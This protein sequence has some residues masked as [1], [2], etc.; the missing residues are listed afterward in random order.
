VR[1]PSTTLTRT[2]AAEAAAACGILLA[3]ILPAMTA[4]CDAD[5]E[6]V[7]RSQIDAAIVDWA[8]HQC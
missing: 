3:I 1:K 4:A 5:A 7:T 6:T 2:V 8:S